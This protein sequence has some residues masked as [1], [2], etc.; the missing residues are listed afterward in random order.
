MKKV[1]KREPTEAYLM[2]LQAIRPED[3]MRVEDEVKL[4]KQIQKAESDV[5]AAIYKLL[6]ANQ[7]F[8]YS[9]A[10]QYASDKSTLDVLMTEGNLGLKHAIYKFDESRGFKFITYAV[11]WIRKSIQQTIEH[12]TR[13]DGTLKGLS[14]QELDILRMYFGFGQEKAPLEE[15]QAKYNLTP[16]GAVA[17][18]DQALRKLFKSK[19]K[20]ST[21]KALLL[22]KSESLEK[23]RTEE[24]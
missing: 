8:V 10:K 3:L 22:E 15:I 20:L 17:I 5:D 4:I 2:S 21:V 9:V 23:I 11:W 18:K 13:E 19:E 6:R 24:L 14:E 7:R 16:Q 12:K 1:I